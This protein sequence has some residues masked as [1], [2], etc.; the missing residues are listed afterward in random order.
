MR[1]DKDLR[2]PIHASVALAILAAGCPRRPT[3]EID[4]PAAAGAMAPNLAATAGGWLMTWVEPGSGGHRVRFARFAAGAW[5]AP[6]TIAEGAAIVANWADVPSV[7]AA[8]DGALVAHWA[9]ASTDEAYDVVLAR[10]ED[11]GAS[12]RRLGVPHRDGTRTEHGFVSL[13]GEGAAV[14]AVWLDGRAGTTALRSALVGVSIGEEEVIDARVC[15][16]CGTAAIATEGGTLVAYRDRS[17][18]ELRDIATAR[19]ASEG[20]SE[21]SAVHGDGWKIAGC[22]VNG[23]GGRRRRRPGRGR[24]VHPRRRPALGACRL[25]VGRRRHLR[26]PDRRR[27]ARPARPRRCR[28]PRRRGHRELDGVRG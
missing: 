6:S 1:Y 21:P 3:R 24:L 22:P 17:G 10:S 27:R 7:A 13:V 28:R 12:W 26:R 19:R 14:R 4:P 11:G 20:W 15:D 23:P 18:D 25:L 8:A 16:C 5:N 9:E 2:R